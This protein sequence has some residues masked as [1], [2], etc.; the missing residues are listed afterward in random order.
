L[1]GKEDSAYFFPKPW[2]SSHS[3]PNLLIIEDSWLHSVRHAA[4]GRTSLA[5]WSAQCRDFY[6]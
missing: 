4:L 6:L 2:C 3:G 1:Q 5:E